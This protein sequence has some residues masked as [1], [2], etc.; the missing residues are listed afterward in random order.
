MNKVTLQIPVNKSLK[1]SAEQ[2]ALESGFSSLQEALRVF[3]T[4]LAKKTITFGFSE[5]TPDEVLT[6]RQ[7]AIL[8]KKY[9]KARKEIERGEGVTVNSVDEMMKYLRA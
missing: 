4:Q 7:E 2:A 6:P 9:E 5:G 3:M 1:I 8:T